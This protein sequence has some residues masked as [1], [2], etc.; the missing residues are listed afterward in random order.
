MPRFRLT[1]PVRVSL[2]IHHIPLAAGV[3]FAVAILISYVWAVLNDHVPPIF[4]YISD[5]GTFAPESCFFGQLL[6]IGAVLVALTVYLRYI[7]LRDFVHVDNFP[8][9]GCLSRLSVTLGLISSFGVSLVANFQEVNQ[10]ELHIVGANMVFGLGAIYMWVETY[11]TYKIHPGRESKW[12]CHFRLICAVV[13]LLAFVNMMVTIAVAFHYYKP[14]DNRQPVY[15]LPEDGGWEWHTAS[16]VSEWVVATM[17]VL[18]F[19]SYTKEFK[20]FKLI[21]PK[22]VLAEA[23]PSDSICE[24]SDTEPVYP[25]FAA[26]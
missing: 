17:E 11:I 8:R 14:L 2:F 10:I 6:N 25:S 18:F 23:T 20:R 1:F 24:S 9:F 4:P 13:G 22:L 19:S 3:V 26:V 7:E 5:T 12:M 16:S 15:W 21:F